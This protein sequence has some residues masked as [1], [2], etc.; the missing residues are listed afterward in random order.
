M[1]IG[2]FCRG[3]FQ[4]GCGL[5]MK[6]AVKIKVDELMFLLEAAEEFRERDHRRDRDRLGATAYSV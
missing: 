4:Q 5:G 1:Q 2:I 3:R 6:L